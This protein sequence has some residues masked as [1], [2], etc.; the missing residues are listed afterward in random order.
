MSSKK[1]SF[2]GPE[3]GTLHNPRKTRKSPY[4]ARPIITVP[5]QRPKDFVKNNSKK[6]SMGQFR[7]KTNNSSTREKNQGREQNV[8]NQVPVD[9]D[10]PSTEIEGTDSSQG[11]ENDSVTQSEEPKTTEV[12]RESSQNDKKE[13]DAEREDDGEQNGEIHSDPA[14]SENTA[15]DVARDSEEPNNDNSVTSGVKLRS[16]KSSSENINKSFSANNAEPKESFISPEI[17]LDHDGETMIMFCSD[18]KSSVCSECIRTKHKEH[19]WVQLHKAGIEMRKKLTQY[20]TDINKTILPN[21]AACLEKARMEK[22]RV[23]SQTMKKMEEIVAQRDRILETV[24]GLSQVMLNSCE[25]ELKGND[26]T[27]NKMETDVS[28]LELV[29]S[30][31]EDATLNCAS[32]AETVQMETRLS[33]ILLKTEPNEATFNADINFIPGEIDT[34]QIQI[35]LGKLIG[36]EDETAEQ[37]D[38]NPDEVAMVSSRSPRRPLRPLNDF[39]KCVQCKRMVK[40]V[41]KVKYM[42]GHKICNYCWFATMNSTRCPKCNTL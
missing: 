17:C 19:D 35:M 4:A 25:E 6:M 15:I 21:L 10:K 27:I 9:M 37:A 38:D 20:R 31:L 41:I 26:I 34:D 33:S 36:L 40:N 30:K 24:S 29:A 12:L 13:N 3:T 8:Q 7:S 2:L 32:D 16:L 42:C 18:C 28:E 22:E 5:T 39:Q 1:S 14:K 23:Q 11:R